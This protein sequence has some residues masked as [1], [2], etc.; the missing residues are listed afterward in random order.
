M[1]S[2]PLT[3]RFAL[4]RVIWLRVRSKSGESWRAG[5]VTAGAPQVWLEG[6]GELDF[7][8]LNLPQQLEVI[9]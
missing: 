2:G 1:L 5:G 7:E 3:P 9:A 4:D 8:E 6:F